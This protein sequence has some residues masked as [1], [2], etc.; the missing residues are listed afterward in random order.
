MGGNGS[1]GNDDIREN[2]IWKQ[3]KIKLTL[4]NWR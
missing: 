3:I 1:N 2:W 4:K